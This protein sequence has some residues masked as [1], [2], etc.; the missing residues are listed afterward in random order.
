MLSRQTFISIENKQLARG[1]DH[2][3]AHLQHDFFTAYAA[4]S[5]LA[6]VREHASSFVPPPPVFVFSG[7]PLLLTLAGLLQGWAPPASGAGAALPR[8]I[9]CCVVTIS[10]LLGSLFVLVPQAAALFPSGS[11]AAVTAIFIFSRQ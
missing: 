9:N 7:R 10:V 2:W 3:P 6:R 5:S 11:S 4:L 8:L 1:V